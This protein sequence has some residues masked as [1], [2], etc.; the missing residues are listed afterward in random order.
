[1]QEPE[2]LEHEEQKD[3]NRTV[4]N[5]KVLPQMPQTPTA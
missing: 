4:G 3:D 1:M 2:L 5:E